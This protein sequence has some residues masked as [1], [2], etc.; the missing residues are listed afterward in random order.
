MG[1]N[2]ESQIPNL[3][4]IPINDKRNPKPRLPNV[5]VIAIWDF[6]FV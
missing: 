5:S 1:E 2:P 4:Q 6:G 3:K